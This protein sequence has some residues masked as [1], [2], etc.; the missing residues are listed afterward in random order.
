MA[1]YCRGMT[2]KVTCGLT[3]CTPG[4]APGPT[5]G[6]EY[7]NILPFSYH[8]YIMCSCVNSADEDIDSKFPSNVV[9]Y[10]DG[11]CIWV[12][13]GLFISSCAI[14]IR[15]FPFDDQKCR[16]KFGSWTYD[17]GSINMSLKTDGAGPVDLDTYQ[18][19]GEWKL[20]GEFLARSLQNKCSSE[21]Q[22]INV[23]ASIN[24][25]NCFHRL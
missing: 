19:S 18:E 24:T 21:L 23:L 20:V 4:S 1:A 2:E 12:P 6:N 13:L 5:L 11:L 16:M 9:V 10:A 3:A 8:V 15:W 25:T 7:G 17:L 22:P 14:D